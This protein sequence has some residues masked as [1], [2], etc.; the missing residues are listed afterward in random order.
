M[1]EI[2]NKQI[3]SGCHACYNMCPKKCITMQANNEGFLYPVIDEENCINCGQC[4][5][6]CPVLKDYRGNPKGQAFAC[7]NKN[8]E[9][10]GRSSS[11]GVFTL[12]AENIIN[13]GGAVFGA[14]FDDGLS[15]HHVE[16][17]AISELGRL[18]GSKY[19]QSR[20]EDTYA[21]TKEYLASG[22]LVLFT[23]TPCQI[24]GLKSF[25]GKDYDNLIMQDIIC[26]GVPSPKIW[27]MY[28]KYRERVAG[29]KIHNV[30]FRNKKMGWK[31]YSV[32]FEF[33]NHTEYDQT[34]SK[35]LFMQSF[36]ADL[37]LRP[38]CYRCHSKSLQRESDITLADFWGIE[39]VAPE[40]FDDKGTSLVF[41]NTLKG[42]KIFREISKNMKYKEVD[43]DESAK[44]NSAAFKSCILPINRERFMQSVNEY[45]FDKCVNKF[46][47]RSFARRA[48]SKVKRLLKR[49]CNHVQ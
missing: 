39:N 47:K 31:A 36:L 38:S 45:N 9:I 14:A 43:I 49:M 22:R 23:G 13:K 25:L 19:V 34:P 42:Q 8:E 12:I 10:R 26:H 33:K 4:N 46:A 17:S 41:V 30:F 48:A 29:A 15:V 5:K 18:R 24:S 35:D 21:K 7:I 11:G 27:Q 32:H 37:C 1:Q 3:C 44:Y 28:I 40:M 2:A 16:V 20:I 6:A